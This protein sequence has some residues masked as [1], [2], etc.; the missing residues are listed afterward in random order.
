MNKER[1]VSRKR[2]PNS[3]IDTEVESFAEKLNIQYNAKAAFKNPWGAF[4]CLQ[5]ASYEA[6]YSKT[7]CDPDKSNYQ[8]I[9]ETLRSEWPE[10]T[11][12]TVEQL[13]VDDADITKILGITSLITNSA[14]SF[15]KAEAERDI[16]TNKNIE[17]NNEYLE[18]YICDIQSALKILKLKHQDRLE[19]IGVLEAIIFHACF[20]F[21]PSLGLSKEQV[22]LSLADLM[23][24]LFENPLG[25][26]S[27]YK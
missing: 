9:L 2:L 17:N 23:Q 20:H 26:G 24:A 25:E 6:L 3:N 8:L 7:N 13:Y 5:Y 10:L 19:P 1:P 12:E 14:L 27:E 11:C 21:S 18:N 22:M 15:T 16:Q 4:A